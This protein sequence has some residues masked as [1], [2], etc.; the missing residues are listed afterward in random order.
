MGIFRKHQVADGAAFAIS[1]D[2]HSVSSSFIERHGCEC[3]RF[4]GQPVVD[5]TG[6]CS[7]KSS[8]LISSRELKGDPQSYRLCLITEHHS[9][10]SSRT[11][12]AHC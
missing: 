10:D 12:R 3:L 8:I 9:L 2:M 11:F 7:T 6:P 1:R 5:F 4:S